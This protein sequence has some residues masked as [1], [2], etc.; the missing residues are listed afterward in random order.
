M[1]VRE[2]MT[3]GTQ[4]LQDSESVTKAASLM[5][6]LNVGALPIFQ[7]GKIS[8]ILTDR[9]IVV[10]CIGVSLN[11][12]HTSIGEIMSKEVK[13]CNEDADISDAAKIMENNKIRRLIVINNSAKVTGMLSVGDIAVKGSKELGGDVLEKISE[14]I[15][16]RNK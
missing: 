1:K 15:G 2:I 7:D 11:P 8:G 6:E 13:T 12:M 5:R 4:G 16:P 14:P 10:G 9:D 3:S